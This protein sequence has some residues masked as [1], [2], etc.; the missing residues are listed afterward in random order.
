MG[1]GGSEAPK[2]SPVGASRNS[3]RV[4]AR[5]ALGIVRGA[6]AAGVPVR[7]WWPPAVV[8]AGFCGSTFLWER[9]GVRFHAGTID[10]FAQLLDPPLLANRLGESLWHLHAQPPLFNLAVGWALKASPQDPGAPLRW[11]F[12]AAGLGTALALLAALR[13]LRFPPAAA[14]ALAV[15]FT[16]TPTFAV[17][18]HWCFYPHLALACLAAAAAFLLASG[19]G[20]RPV[21][22]GL[23][24]AAL[25]VLAMTRSLYHPL[26]LAA[27]AAIAVR[28]AP[29]GRRRAAAAATAPAV[30]VG[31]AWAAKN[32]VMFGFFGTSSWG[33]NS[34][35]RMLTESVDPPALEAMVASG[36]ISPISREWEFSPPAVYVG[37]LA[38]DRPGTGIPALDE[39]AKTR[40]RENPV[41]YNHW[42]YPIASREYARNALALLRRHPGAYLESVRFTARRWLD[43][44]TD[45]VFLRTI[46]W[47]VR[48]QIAPFE[49]AERSPVAR[50]AMLLVLAWA[51]ARL[52]RGTGPPGE[53]LFLAFAVGTILWAGAAGILLEY[54]ENNRFR[55]HLAPLAFLLAATALRD[56]AA[57]LRARLGGS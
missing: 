9:E 25:G 34:L 44:V 14:A 24:F 30:L 26:Y 16:A 21:L 48:A 45:D 33:G 31:F 11:L 47:P 5:P 4:R 1:E 40:T 38:P 12:L 57:A 3:A 53:R 15:A 13:A 52:V 22:L 8:T 36:E 39:T 2:I 54:G 27:A 46:R 7:R 18:E 10:H 37:L 51:A 19:R 23:G 17:Y 28:M 42:V 43:P 6:G 50:G 35:H 29:A 32:L 49:A 41:N 56:A 20:G 55:W